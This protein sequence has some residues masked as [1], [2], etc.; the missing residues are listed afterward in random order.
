M[1]VLIT[2][3]KQSGRLQLTRRVY[4]PPTYGFTLGPANRSSATKLIS[5]ADKQTIPNQR[6]ASDNTKNPVQNV[7]RSS[8]SKSFSHMTRGHRTVPSS[9]SAHERPQTSSSVDRLFRNSRSQHL[10][11]ETLVGQPDMSRYGMKFETQFVITEDVSN[12]IDSPA[13]RFNPRRVYEDLIAEDQNNSLEHLDHH[14]NKAW[15]HEPNSRQ[16]GSNSNGHGSSYGMLYNQNFKAVGRPFALLEPL[17]VAMPQQHMANRHTS[18]HQFETTSNDGGMRTQLSPNY[19]W[20]DTY[21]GS[22]NQQ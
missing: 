22:A 8:S 10:L 21:R 9:S 18:D 3:R 11:N 17:Q 16:E 14:S 12:E 2:I 19:E 6:V 1:F 7:Q 15:D 20:E 13:G 4:H 5:S